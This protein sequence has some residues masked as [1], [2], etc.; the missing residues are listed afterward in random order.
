MV[1]GL[2]SLYSSY[3]SGLIAGLEVL[4]NETRYPILARLVVE[5][6]IWIEDG[7]YVGRADD[8]TVCVLG[9]VA[10]PETVERTLIRAGGRP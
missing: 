9:T 2:A 3:A 1:F 6:S 5:G 10:F 7:E 4:M 8:G